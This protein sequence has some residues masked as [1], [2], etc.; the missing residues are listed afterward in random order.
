MVRVVSSPARPRAK[1]VRTLTIV[2]RTCR[3]QSGRAR[4]SRRGMLVSS[5]TT[6]RF[7]ERGPRPPLVRQHAASLR[8][9]LVDTAAHNCGPGKESP[10]P[11][12]HTSREVVLRSAS[13]QMRRRTRSSG[14]VRGASNVVAIRIAIASQDVDESGSDTSHVRGQWHSARQTELAGN[15]A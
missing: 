4:S 6:H 1:G 9:E 2:L 3:L 8:R 14:S 5:D 15:S 12:V 7:H 10:Q 13:W 11:R